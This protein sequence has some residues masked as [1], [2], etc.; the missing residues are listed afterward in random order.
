MNG[1]QS[2]KQGWIRTSAGRIFGFFFF[3]GRRAKKTR[4][5]VLISLMPL[6]QATVIKTSEFS[7]RAPGGEGL[8]IFSNFLMIFYLQF[9]L[10]ILT[11]F[12]GTSVASEDV[13]GRTLPFLL[14]RPLSKVGIVLG[15]YAAYSL[16]TSIILLA[17]F[18]ASFLILAG[19]ELL[20]PRAWGIFV[21]FALVLVLG[22]LCYTS[23]F[24]FL[25]ALLKRSIFAGLVFGFGW[26]SVISY[27][28][29]STQ[30]FSIVH[31]LKS[32]LPSTPGGRFSFLMFRLEP[33]RPALAFLA[34]VLITAFFLGLAGFLFRWK[35]YLSE[36]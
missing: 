14:T 16:L 7:R 23:F 19:G 17:S 13:E 9:F 28:P 15:K 10:I 8:A 26:E 2:V 5:F 29:G 35:E 27:F 36:E 25:G 34:L 4:V 6:L 18:L 22:V 31:Y 11:L 21:R 12:Y 24:T 3:L 1:A 32:L 33:T 20:N 30:R